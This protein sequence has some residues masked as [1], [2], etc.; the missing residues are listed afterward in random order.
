MAR[1]LG[2]DVGNR[3]IGV[4]VSDTSKVIAR[5]V[6]VIDRKVQNAMRR[7]N[8]L[9][10]EYQPDEIILGYPWNANGSAG[11]QA[12]HVE[13][14]AAQLRASIQIPLAFC[15]ERYSTGEAQEIINANR[16][17]KDQVRHDDAI[18]A[19]II[20]QRYLDDRRSVEAEMDAV[21]DEDTLSGDLP[22]E[23]S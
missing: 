15:D 16:R 23:R 5:P 22:N 1:S 18:A 4:A 11:E 12:H 2:L 6:E 13:E 21:Q 8:E 10:K 9:V 20:L 3:R 7:L 19:A 14:F 17:K